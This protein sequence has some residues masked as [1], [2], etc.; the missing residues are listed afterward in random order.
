MDNIVRLVS[1]SGHTSIIITGFL[2]LKE[3]KQIDFVFDE[4]FGQ[5][6]DCPHE[7]IIEA[8]INGKSIAF[9]LFDGSEDIITPKFQHYV[10]SKDAYFKRSYA[11]EEIQALPNECRDKVFPLGLFYRVTYPGNPLYKDEKKLT[12]NER[13]FGNKPK[14]YYT[15]DKFETKGECVIQ[16]NPQVMFF[17]RLWGSADDSEKAAD[18]SLNAMRIET[19]RLL[20]SKLEGVFIGG[21][22]DTDL[23]RKL[24]PDI[25]LP[26][27]YTRR[28]HY[29]AIMKKTPISISSEGLH[30][31][32]NGKIAEAVAAGRA[33]VC[34]KLHYEVPGNFH[35]GANYLAYTTPHECLNCVEKLLSN[36]ALLKD[37]QKNNVEYYE[38]YSRPDK[39]VQNALMKANAMEA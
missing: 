33:I 8:E 14:S 34:E 17:T 20:K 1:K 6:N 27:K 35:E 24:C 25:I 21:I 10:A 7:H 38:N 13:L 5:W 26:G 37:L 28:D 32:I 2:M 18:R 16:S 30:R 22:Q 29:I 12:W 3:Q 36:R 19:I 9:D 23:A 31:S 11:L 39:I 4:R 15:P